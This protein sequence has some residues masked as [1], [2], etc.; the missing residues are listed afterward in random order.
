MVGELNHVL[1]NKTRIDQDYVNY[2]IAK[3]KVKGYTAT[4]IKNKSDLKVFDKKEEPTKHLLIIESESVMNENKEI[5]QKIITGHNTNQIMLLI[6]A[7]GTK[8]DRELWRH[9][10][11]NCRS[12]Y[13]F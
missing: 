6:N 12:R 3:I 4:L 10:F 5:I 1:I 2:L 13:G 7:D 11:V 8:V 9:I